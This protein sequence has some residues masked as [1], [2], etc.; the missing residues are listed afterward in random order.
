MKSRLRTTSQGADTIVW[1]AISKEAETSVRNGAF[2]FDRKEVSQHL[3]LAFTKCKE[4]TVE[5]FVKECERL[6][7]G[8]LGSSA[9]A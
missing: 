1:A 6:V 8:C 3:P 4:G 2:L 9:S 5:L 7:E